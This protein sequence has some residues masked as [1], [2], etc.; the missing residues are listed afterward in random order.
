MQRITRASLSTN[1]EAY[2]TKKQA[3]VD[4]LEQPDIERLWKNARSTKALGDV[5]STLRMMC[6]PRE[7]CMYCL[8]SHGCDIE[9]FRPKV[10]YPS[11]AFRWSNMLLCCTECG[12][13]KGSRFPTHN[14]VPL[15]IDP[16]REDPWIYLEFDPETGN[17][18]ARFD[19]TI[20]DWSPKG[21][22]TVDILKLNQREALSV[23][24]KT[25]F[26]RLAK[27]VKEKLEQPDGISADILCND[28][29]EVD[30]HGLLPWCFGPSGKTVDPFQRL[31][32][33]H[34]E[35]WS[36]CVSRLT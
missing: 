33:Q 25:T 32:K 6:G 20:D 28:L 16:T 7:R 2:L 18:D 11:H 8:D 26:R 3:H 12:R 5:I 23:V 27:I 15:L 19:L 17:I 36:E 24:Y 21:T 14:D 4:T 10:D 30:D 29:L 31:Q 9:H 22:C 35:V 1:T 34:A 13:F